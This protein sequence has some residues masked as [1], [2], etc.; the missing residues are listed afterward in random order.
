MVLD[1]QMHICLVD[2]GLAYI[3]GANR[4]TH[5]GLVYGSAYYLAPEV[6]RG[7]RADER[8]DLYALGVMLYELCTGRLPFYDE[9]P[10]QVMSQ[11]CHNLPLLPGR[12]NAD[13]PASL[14]TVILKLLAKRPDERFQSAREARAALDRVAF[15]QEGR[16]S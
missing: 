3:A 2:F 4:L 8:S 16:S 11:H 9:N 14:E 1:E 10:A 5:E 6:I 7:Q 13:V 15:A 12:L